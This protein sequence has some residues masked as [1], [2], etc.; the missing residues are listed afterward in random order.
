MVDISLQV[1]LSDKDM[2]LEMSITRYKG[3]HVLQ[4]TNNHTVDCPRKDS[5]LSEVFQIYK[6]SWIFPIYVSNPKLIFV[7]VILYIELHGIVVFTL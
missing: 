2:Y 6:I 1:Y 3:K 5:M 7:P 4:K